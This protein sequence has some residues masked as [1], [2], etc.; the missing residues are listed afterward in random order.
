MGERPSPEIQNPYNDIFIQHH[1][2]IL[3]PINQRPV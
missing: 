3:Q 2:S 1:T